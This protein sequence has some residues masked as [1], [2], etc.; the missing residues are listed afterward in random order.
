MTCFSFM[1]EYHIHL[2]VKVKLVCALQ[3]EDNS[4]RSLSHGWIIL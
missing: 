3:Y 2:P 1:P 4:I